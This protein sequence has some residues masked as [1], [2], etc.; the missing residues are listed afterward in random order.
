[1]MA[2]SLMAIVVAAVLGA[3]ASHTGKTAKVLRQKTAAQY[4]PKMVSMLI[5]TA[6]ISELLKAVEHAS[7][8]NV[9]AALMLLAILLATRSGTENGMH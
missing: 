6:Q 5:I 2:L 4:A 8:V 7:F 9:A 1:M 3:A